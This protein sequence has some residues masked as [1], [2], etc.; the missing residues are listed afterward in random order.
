MAGYPGRRR[1]GIRVD[2]RVEHIQ[3]RCQIVAAPYRQ[4]VSDRL[5]WQAAGR[6][7]F[8]RAHGRSNPRVAYAENYTGDMYSEKVSSV[9]RHTK[10]YQSIQEAALDE[11]GSRAALLRNSEGVPE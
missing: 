9:Q 11:V 7:A 1:V 4:F 3:Q 6:G 8:P 5:E 10:A 2:E